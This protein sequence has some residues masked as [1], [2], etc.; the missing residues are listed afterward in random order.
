MFTNYVTYC[1][2]C[3][4]KNSTCVTFQVQDELQSIDDKC[5][6]LQSKLDDQK[7]L[8]L[9]VINTWQQY[10]DDKSA[11]EKVINIIQPVL[12]EDMI[13]VTY[14]DSKKALDQYKVFSY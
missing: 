10:N 12:Q 14:E 4:I 13:Y 7:E 5:S 8:H 11:V 3:A 9:A 2:E 1:V 6:N